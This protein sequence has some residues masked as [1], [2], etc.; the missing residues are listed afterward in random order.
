[1]G[2]KLLNT[3]LKIKTK[4]KEAIKKIS[5]EH[6]YDKKIVI[7]TSIYMYRFL[8]EDK[9]I[10]NFYLMCSLFRHY[11]I[12]PLFVFDG[13]PP[14]EK[15]ETIKKRKEEK[16]KAKE[17]YE[18]LNN[19]LENEQLSINDKK[20]IEEQMLELK[21]SFIHIKN[22][23]IRDLKGLFDS[24]GVNYIDA[25][26]EAEQLCAKIVLQKKA[27]ACLSEDTDLFVYG[28]PRVLRYLSLKNQSFVLYTFKD[29]L[30]SLGLTKIEFQKICILSG[31]DYLENNNKTIF[32]YYNI[33]KKWK[34]LKSK[35]N[36]KVDFYEYLQE[37]HSKILPSNI[38][39]L[40][41]ILNIFTSNFIKIILQNDYHF[42]NSNIKMNELKNILYQ[43]NFIFV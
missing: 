11:N 41:N 31:C 24:M 30:H 10:E 33:F 36:I 23:N 14:N 32:H 37:K 29:I 42:N 21:K 2:I 27:Y 40:H 5:F 6:L 9:L 26:G 43:H 4:N 38:E 12:H 13:K 18:F 20:E 15:D 25:N 7:D 17:E 3:F 16:Q 19:K 22:Q 39:K 35:G 34:S 8:G 1:M 28:C